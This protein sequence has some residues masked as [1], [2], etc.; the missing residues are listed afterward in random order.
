MSK[1]SL[2]TQLTIL[3][4][5]EYNVAIW[6]K[7]LKHPR[8]QHAVERLNSVQPAKK[9]I[10]WRCL[11]YYSRLLSFLMPPTWAIKLALLDWKV[12]EI[13][14][15]HLLI[16]I[17]K[18]KLRW[19]QKNDLK[20]VVV[21]GSYAKTS[22]KHMLNHALSL[23]QH[24]LMTP[25]SYN[26]P[27]GIALT[28]IRQLT[29]RHKIFIV[30]LGEYQKGDLDPLLNWLH[31]D[32]GVLTP[33]GVSHSE[34]WSSLDDQIDIFASLWK[35]KYSPQQLII[36]DSNK[37]IFNS[38]QKQ[39]SSFRKS[40]PTIIWYGTNSNSDLY[41][42]QEDVSLNCSQAKLQLRHIQAT[43]SNL[44]SHHKSLTLK[45]RLLGHAHLQNQLPALVLADYYS[46]NF[47]SA[48][49]AMQYAPDVPRRLQVITHHSRVFIDNSY[50]TSPGS[51]KQSAQLIR[52]LKLTN[53][54]IVTGGFVE[55]SAKL[56]TVSHR[57]MAT[58]IAEV[59][60]AAVIIKSRYNQELIDQL[61]Q[62]VTTNQNKLQKVIV[63]DNHESA[64]QKITELDLSIDFLW[65]EGGMR[66]I[67][68]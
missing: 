62:K 48:L 18:I 14:T 26:T 4:Q 10:K 33:I 35:H 5:A 20:V 50:N 17:S 30:E 7:W 38:S 1:Y 31:P 21:A 57:Q 42:Y 51:W 47:L 49:Q 34:R 60:T 52:Q 32:S 64:M 8:S 15:T 12:L 58:D 40:F 44:K 61:N 11:Y 25:A 27:L 28:I 13:I 41:L 6:S 53:L 66:E 63:V 22:V 37:E 29:T 9:T 56:N 55:L 2:T 43:D 65:L 16:N 23:Q 19:L 3:Q 59:A 67:Y 46:H 45:T 68:Q 39:I 54:V 24:T 36:A